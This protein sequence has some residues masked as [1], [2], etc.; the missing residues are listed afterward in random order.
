[1][2]G[3]RINPAKRALALTGRLSA[4]V[5]TGTDKVRSGYGNGDSLLLD[6][7]HRFFAVA[8][9]SERF[10]MASRALLQRLARD[11]FRQGAPQGPEGWLE[12]VNRAYARQNYIH[13]T[14]LTCVALE[15]RGEGRLAHVLHGGDSIALFLDRTTGKVLYRTGVDMNF[16]G[17]AERIDRTATVPLGGPNGLVVLAT[18]GLADVARLSGVSIEALCKE[19]TRRYPLHAFPGIVLRFLASKRPSPEY[20]DIGFMAFSPPELDKVAKGCFLMG[21]TGA[22]EEAVLRRRM[23]EARFPDVWTSPETAGDLPA[24][25]VLDLP[26]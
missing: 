2:E 8:D 13:K 25:G 9:S 11:L 10:P 24:M 23:E 7:T 4:C 26:G 22:Q 1:M 14:T 3:L 20:D 16:A 15:S 12:L 17:R 18:D 5:I 21:G 19:S 6:F